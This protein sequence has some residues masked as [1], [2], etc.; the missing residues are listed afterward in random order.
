MS[1]ESPVVELY[2]SNGNPLSVQNGVAI[3]A[4]TPALMFAGSDGTNSRYITIDSSGHPI[5]V[6]AGVA[7]TPSGGVI[8]IQGV[9]S[10]TVVP[11]SGTITANIGTT[12]GLALDTSVNGI[13][14]S[15]G[16]TTSGQKGPLIQGAV[17][18]AAPT[19]STA[20]TSPLSL[21][22]A[23]ALRIDGSAVTQPVSGTVTANAG[24]GT[25][26]IAGTVTANAGTGNFNNSA[27]GTV[28]SAVPSSAGLAGFSDGTNTQLARV[29][30]VDTG[31]GTQYV[32]GVNLRLSANGGSVE[33][34]T[35][36]NPIR[37]DPTGTTTQ[38]VSGTVTAN[39]GTGNFTVVQATASNLLANVGG[40][41]ASGAAVSGNPVR[42]GGSDGANTRDILV[43]ASGR[44]IVIGAAANGAAVAGNPVL[45]AGSDGANARSIR[46]ATDGTVRIDPTGT[47]TQPVSGTVTANIGTT[48]GLALD[49]TL[50]KLTI[51]QGTA[52]GTNT[53]ALMGGS[54]TTGAPTYTTG[55]INPL[56]LTTAGALRVDGS[57]V[58]QPVSGTVTAN[59][60]TGNFTVIGTATDNTANSTAKL[61]VMAALANTSAPSWTNGNMVPL[62]VDT[63]GNLRITGSISASNPS[64]STT[65]TSPPASATYIGG[66]VTTSAP[67]YTTGQMNALSLD[68]SGNLRVTGTFSSSGVADTTAT[69]SLNA[70]NAAVQVALAGQQGAAMQLVAGTLQGTI[71]PEL[72]VDGGT[73]WVST[74]FEDPTNNAIV[75]AFV[76]SSNNTAKT[77][78][79][80]VTSGASHV[81]IRV[82]AFTSGTATCNLRAS[83]ANDPSLTWVG[84]TNATAP[85]S[86]VLVGGKDASGKMQ[87]P[88]VDVILGQTVEQMSVASTIT[89]PG[90]AA[91][92]IFAFTNAYGS[93]RTSPES[94]TVFTDIFDGSIIDPVKWTTT[95]TVT[96]GSGLMTINAGTVAGN[97]ATLQG[98][99]TNVNLGL[100]FEIWGCTAQFTGPAT[101]TYRFIGV[102]TQSGGTP[103][104]AIGFEYDTTGT[105]YAVVYAGGSNVYRSSALTPSPG[106]SFNRY[107]FHFRSD[108]TLFYYQ[109]S[110]YPNASVSFTTPNIQTLAPLFFVKNGGSTLGSNAIINLQGV[111]TTDTG[112]NA[113]QLSDGKYPH[114][115]A[116]VDQNG[117]L[118]VRPGFDTLLSFDAIEGST[119]N[120]WLWKTTATGMSVSVSTGSII[121]NGTTTSGNNVNITTNVQ[122]SFAVG[123]SVKGVWRVAVINFANTFI[124]FGF[125]APSGTSNLGGDSAYFKIDA[126]GNL[127]GY[128]YSGGS[129][130]STGNIVGVINSGNY[131]EYSIEVSDRQA[132]FKIESA[133]QKLFDMTL[134]SVN[135]Q[136]RSFTVSHLPAFVRQANTGTPALGTTVDVGAFEVHL[137]D[138]NTTKKWEYQMAAAG[139]SATVSPTTFAQTAQLAAAAGPTAGT[140]SNTAALYTT[141]GGEY[142]CNA[143]ATSE[144]LLSIFAFTVPSPYTFYLTGLFIPPPIVNNAAVATTGTILEFF[145]IVNCATTNI[146]TGGGQRFTVPGFFSV[147]VSA[148]VGTVFNGVAGQWTP[149]TPI[150]CQPNTVIHIGYKVVLGTA[151][152]SNRQRG[153][154]YVDGFF[155]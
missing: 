25:F 125:G 81:R 136:P 151:T 39:A 153:S 32:Q 101:G 69:G 57:G 116:E 119:L 147:A 148:A 122:Y 111:G 96:Q 38:P 27:I 120:S 141:L 102:G 94:T 15:Q 127:D 19:Y 134:A 74:Y 143:T 16:S 31:G 86:A 76:F 80:V 89:S 138:I 53:Q 42:I 11:I 131:F 37:V 61:P 67:S 133:T 29:F 65:G 4:N 71:V 50:A 121:L 68:T 146:N 22:T 66:S 64:V 14:L 59:A 40:L 13:L 83:F 44:Q 79:I 99:I 103:T 70:L 78:S 137:L 10:G 87:V 108:L 8:S 51:S 100:E 113:S 34:G 17:T 49:A 95:G 150:A 104:D 149:T 112:R 93:L 72:S 118:Y 110:E 92:G 144:N 52:L 107:G 98:N 91:R 115:R 35:N 123:G 128:F 21:T 62:S 5:V 139:R 85:I 154:V 84:P 106:T 90:G 48:N 47:T 24:T 3:P 140:P 132:R 75:S 26:N 60:G 43:D 63:S 97:S 9:A 2:D 77:Q 20:Q 18:T 117:K 105:L 129:Q 73:T 33:F 36:S 56:S 58:T 7:G 126:N 142:I 152:A 54:V 124:D 6:G 45:I 88:Q 109:Q 130:V 12:N 1:G 28:G 55:Q 114:R 82:S 23:G 145:C 155:E 41:G 46:T 30:D 135:N